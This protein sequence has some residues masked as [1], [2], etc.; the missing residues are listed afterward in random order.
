MRFTLT[1]DCE[2]DAF[3]DEAGKPSPG[4][5]TFEV[6]RILSELAQDLHSPDAIRAQCGILRDTNGN[7]VGRWDLD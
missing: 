7:R 3:C 6:S 4:P 2:N 5:A 1:I